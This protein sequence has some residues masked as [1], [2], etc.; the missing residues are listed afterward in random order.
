MTEHLK[1]QIIW[2]N[3]RQG[4]RDALEWIY[5]NNYA[6][7]FQYARK[8]SKDSDL[9]KDLIQE[10]FVE[11]IDSGSRLSTTNN[12]RFYLLKSLRN[13]LSKFFSKDLKLLG[14]LDDF[15]MFNLVDSIENQLIK[16][17]VEEQIQNQI[18]NALK[19]LS[20][21]QQEIIYLRFYKGLSFNEIAEIFDVEIQTVRN[22]LNRAINS[23]KDDFQKS[24]ITKSLIFFLLELSV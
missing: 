2:D 13:K 11:L 6:S 16:E 24:N 20:A 23:L 3:F 7:L 14:Q 4:S 18:L 9:I 15:T 21:K 8:F 17:E 22:L 1:N 19:K 12:I 10:L 5:E